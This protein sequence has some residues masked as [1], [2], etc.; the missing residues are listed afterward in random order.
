MDTLASHPLVIL[1]LL[2]CQSLVFCSVLFPTPL[3]LQWGFFFLPLPSSNI[4]F[5]LSLCARLVL[6]RLS[7]LIGIAPCLLSSSACPPFLLLPLLC[8][9]REGR[10]AL[11]RLLPCVYLSYLWGVP[12][13]SEFLACMVHLWCLI[14]SGDQHH[15]PKY[16]TVLFS[17][18]RK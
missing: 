8:I 4:V 7:F 17:I 11:D 18:Q 15:V 13:S 12:V 3:C 14:F 2:V 5:S 16:G 9:P 6:R 1:T 10:Q